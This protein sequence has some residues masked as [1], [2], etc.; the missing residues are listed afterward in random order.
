[1]ILIAGRKRARPDEPHLTAHDI[2]ELRQLV[3][4][5]AAQQGAQPG[6]ARVAL[7]LE[8]PS[9]RPTTALQ[10]GVQG[11]RPAV[12]RAKFINYE[13]APSEPEALLPKDNRP[14]VAQQHQQRR[15][16]QHRQAEH[17]QQQSGHSFH[18]AAR[19]GTGRPSK[20]KTAVG[21]RPAARVMKQHR[22]TLRRHRSGTV[23]PNGL[24]DESQDLPLPGPLSGCEHSGHIC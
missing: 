7:K 23:L 1:M 10:P 19:H 5:R 3:D 2:H 6:H 15:H 8:Q 11:L 22:R 14:T 20:P 12:H 21:V 4:K 17:Q 16:R 24:C 13:G 18:T 9:T